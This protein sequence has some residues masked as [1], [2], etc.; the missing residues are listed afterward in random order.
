MSEESTRT[1]VPVSEVIEAIDL[2]INGFKEPIPAS[3]LNAAVLARMV[4]RRL[5]EG[6]P[7]VDYG[8]KA[9]GQ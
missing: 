4:R 5:I 1:S 3:Q 8:N 6:G 7:L 9:A 2:I